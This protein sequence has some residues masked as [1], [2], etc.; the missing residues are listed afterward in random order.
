MLLAGRS[1]LENLSKCFAHK[2]AQVVDFEQLRL[3][4]STSKYKTGSGGR[5]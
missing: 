2:K 3:N 4:L 5:I 1:N